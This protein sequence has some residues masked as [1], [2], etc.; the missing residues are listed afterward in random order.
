[1]DSDQETTEGGARDSMN[2]SESSGDRDESLLCFYLYE[3]RV[4][5]FF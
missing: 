1:M 5:S 4:L 2:I 3:L